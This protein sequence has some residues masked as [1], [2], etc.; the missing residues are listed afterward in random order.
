MISKNDL[1]AGFTAAGITAVSMYHQIWA[2]SV[3]FGGILACI[4]IGKVY[5]QFR[6]TEYLID[7]YKESDS[8]VWEDKY[9]EVK[10]SLFFGTF[11]RL[12]SLLAIA[13]VLL[14]FNTS[15]DLPVVDPT[16]D[17]TII[18]DGVELTPPIHIQRKK[19]EPTFE[20]VVEKKPKLDEAPLKVVEDDIKLLD[21][22]PDVEP[23]L[24]TVTI[25]VPTSDGFPTEEEEKGEGDL[26]KKLLPPPAIVD[27]AEI[28]AMFPGCEDMDRKSEERKS[29]AETAM[30]KF[31]QSSLEYPR[32]AVDV[33][34]EGK[35]FVS[36]VVDV[37][38]LIKD[39]EVTRDIGGGCGEEVVRV[40]H[41]LPQFHPA[42]M[43]GRNVPLRMRIPVKFQLD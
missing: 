22:E 30:M 32:L 14:A 4:L 41:T 13:S 29:C 15:M 20:K 25:D 23:D 2:L 38:G 39:I 37:D 40:L 9:P 35:V 3:L 7:R 16:G 18:E 26:D 19:K 43:G 17:R 24:T 42:K 28:P 10:M 12:G 27:F 21:P 6:N 1:L 36:F 34:I 33:G 11:L 31:I 8:P 5:Y